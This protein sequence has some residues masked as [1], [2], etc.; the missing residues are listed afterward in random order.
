MYVPDGDFVPLAVPLVFVSLSLPSS[1]VLLFFSPY[2]IP[3]TA[4]Y[5]VWDGYKAFPSG[6][7]AMGTCVY[8]VLWLYVVAKLKLYNYKSN[9]RIAREGFP[10]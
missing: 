3:A 8:T 6:H 7:C 10:G 5:G 4:R 2:I 1:Y 9:T